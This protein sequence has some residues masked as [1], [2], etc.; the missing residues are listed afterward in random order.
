MLSLRSRL[1][2]PTFG[3]AFAVNLCFLRVHQLLKDK[4]ISRNKYEKK[5]QR[6]IE[7][8]KQLH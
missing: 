7:K 6:S 3:C 1:E 4:N 5:L 8:P 2:A